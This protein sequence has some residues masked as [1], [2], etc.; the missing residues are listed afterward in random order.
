M[1]LFFEMVSNFF[2][3]CWSLIDSVVLVAG[4][5]LADFIL[6]SLI[7]LMCLGVFWKGAKA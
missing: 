1:M 2:M 5:T 3:D 6:V 4:L 7:A